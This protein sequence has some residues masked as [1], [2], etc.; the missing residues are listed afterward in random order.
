MHRAARFDGL[1]PNVMGEN[2]KVR[3][4][5]PTPEEVRQMRTWI[6]AHRVETTPFDIIVEGATP[7]DDPQKA[8]AAIGPYA[9]AGATWWIE[10]LWTA[11]DLD[12]VLQRIRQGPPRV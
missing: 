4:G 3:M 11:T 8:A 5:P 2:G 9:A 6:E 10:A 12:Q 7:G 1:L